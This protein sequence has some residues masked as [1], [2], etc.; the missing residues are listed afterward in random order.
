M[1]CVLRKFRI[2]PTYGH[3][4]KEKRR[5]LEKKG[6]FFRYS[7]GTKGYRIWIPIEYTIEIS[8]DVVFHFDD[9]VSV[10]FH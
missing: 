9:E 4:P 7:P 3:V 5:K 2:F 10:G 6:I 8:L 1:K